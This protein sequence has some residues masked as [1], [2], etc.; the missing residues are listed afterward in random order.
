MC[1]HFIFLLERTRRAACQTQ[2]RPGLSCRPNHLYVVTLP[3]KAIFLNNILNNIL[4]LEYM[5]LSL[6]G[7]RFE[8]EC[9][10]ANMCHSGNGSTLS[11]GF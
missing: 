8:L 1:D 6:T 5:C 11:P 9:I 10:D 4:T 2:S 7:D 3:I